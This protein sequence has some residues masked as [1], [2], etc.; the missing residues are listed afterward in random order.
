MT[1]GAQSGAFDDLEGL[2][3]DGRE[4]QDG[5]DVYVW[6]MHV[7]IWQKPTKHCKAIILQLKINT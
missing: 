5:G 4:I 3:Q 2:G 7:L 1:K 6:L